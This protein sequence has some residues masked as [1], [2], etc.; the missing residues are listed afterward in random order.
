MYQ[1]RVQRCS[2]DGEQWGP[3][4]HQPATATASSCRLSTLHSPSLDWSLLYIILNL[5]LIQSRLIRTLHYTELYPLPSLDWSLLHFYTELYT[6]PVWT[7]LY[8]TLYWTLRS[9]SLDC[10]ILQFYTEPY[11]HPVWTDLHYKSTLNRTLTQSG[12]FFTTILYWTLKSPSYS[13]NYLQI[14]KN[15][16]VSGSI[17]EQST[18]KPIPMKTTI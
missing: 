9:P 3:S 11:T 5:T 1:C 17:G 13:M 15:T 4:P 18:L 14:C 2:G 6:H 12:L 7:D 8:S 10:F 16:Q